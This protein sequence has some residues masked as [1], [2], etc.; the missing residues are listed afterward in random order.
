MNDNISLLRLQDAWREC[1]RHV[2]HLCLAL[3][4]LDTLYLLRFLKIG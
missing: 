2:Y 3:S 1:E 4:W